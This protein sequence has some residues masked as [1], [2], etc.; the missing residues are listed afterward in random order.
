MSARVTIRSRYLSD[1]LDTLAERT[2]WVSGSKREG[3]SCYVHDI[4]DPARPGTLGPQVCRGLWER[5]TALLATE[6][7]LARVVRRELARRRR[8]ILAQVA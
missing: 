3:E 1:Y 7:S 5:G 6:A 4:S 8:E 2:Y